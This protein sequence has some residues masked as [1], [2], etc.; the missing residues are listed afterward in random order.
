LTDAMLVNP[1]N[2]AELAESMR[3]AML[4]PVEERKKR[5][6][7]MRAVVFENN[8]YRW[9]GKIISTLLRLEAPAPDQG[10]AELLER[11]VR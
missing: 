9:T 8:I 5:M 7:R 3:A 2:E 1:F 10:Y 6:Q 4:M 11:S